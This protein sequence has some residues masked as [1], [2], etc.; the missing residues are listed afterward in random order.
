M[1]NL[2][3][4]FILETEK[5]LNE[6]RQTIQNRELVKAQNIMHRLLGSSADIGADQVNAYCNQLA[7]LI[8]RQNWGDAEKHVP[9]IH[10]SLKL[11]VQY[12]K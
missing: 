2:I 9:L 11:L 8:Q 5:L 4:V 1:Q 6:L 10:E 12:I 3:R 7:S